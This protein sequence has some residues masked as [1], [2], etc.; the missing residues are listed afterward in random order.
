MLLYKEKKEAPRSHQ[1]D[2][3]Y[4]CPP[5][6]RQSEQ[7]ERI[8]IAEI[9]DSTHIKICVPEGYYEQKTSL[10]NVQGCW[11]TQSLL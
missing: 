5:K 6:Q 10:V 1:K 9:G 8:R 7:H 4:T 3:G 11:G 2:G